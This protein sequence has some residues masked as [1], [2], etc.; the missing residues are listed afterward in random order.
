MVTVF[1][2]H[3]ERRMTKYLTAAC[4][5]V[6]W[7][8]AAGAQYTQ[9][10]CDKIRD[11]VATVAAGNG[12][13]YAGAVAAQATAEWAFDAAAKKFA[14][15][16]AEL[17]GA[18]GEGDWITLND[19]LS[20]ASNAGQAADTML[21]EGY[22]WRAMGAAYSTYCDTAYGKSDWDAC[23][24]FGNEAGSCY[25]LSTDDYLYPCQSVYAACAFNALAASALMDEYLNP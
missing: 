20:A 19:Y 5:V 25:L 9:A 22:G 11:S 6:L 7:A 3:G 14:D 8:G 23:G 24:G 17:A 4:A 18:M 2:Q 15:N 13:Q 10:D 16:A 12:A 1:N 21:A